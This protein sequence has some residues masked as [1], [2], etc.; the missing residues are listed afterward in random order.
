MLTGHDE[1]QGSCC[2]S[3]AGTGKF[4]EEEASG[5]A[6]SANAMLML[7][8]PDRD[9]GQR[10]RIYLR[11]ALAQVIKKLVVVQQQGAANTA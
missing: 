9:E 11:D 3:I 6:Y 2:D 8:S 1:F 7:A 4:Q 10:C 5:I